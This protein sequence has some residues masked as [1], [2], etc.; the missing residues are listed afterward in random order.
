M[1]AQP[2][3]F[4]SV[5]TL[6]PRQAA[7]QRTL[8]VRAA[9][10]T[11]LHTEIHGPPG[12][13]PI[14]LAHGFTCATGVWRDQIADLSAEYRVIAYDQRGHGRS[15]VPPRRNYSLSYLASDLDAVLEATLAP[16]ETALIAGHSMGGMAVMAWSDRYRHKVG[17]RA[18][19]VALLNTTNGDLLDRLD[20]LPVPRQL[21]AARVLAARQLINTF[22][23]FDVPNAFGRPTRTF[24]RML[25]L[26]AQADPAVVALVYELFTATSP[27][28]RGGCAKMLAAGVGRRHISL[29]GLTVPALVIGSQ[30]DRLTPISQSR[31]I[32]RELPHCVGL[33]E[34][35]GGH[36]AMLEQP[37]R[38]NRELRSLAESVAAARRISS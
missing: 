38:V 9:D 29:T 25:A 15:G 8:T 7:P 12:G 5:T 24:V 37:Q 13:Y 2:S 1:S 10:G 3:G 35:P 4:R 30:R 14:V 19:A 18:D 33:V 16:R 20:L 32:A 11:T 27:S 31:R 36:C 22:G 26:S 28:G 23:S 21:S 34:L 6:T 17:Q